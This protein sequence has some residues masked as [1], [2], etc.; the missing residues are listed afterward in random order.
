M[1]LR[2][3]SCRIL[4]AFLLY[5]LFLSTVPAHAGSLDAFIPAA[6]DQ[7]KK[8][9]CL[10]IPELLKHKKESC[11]IIRAAAQCEKFEKEKPEDSWKFIKCDYDSV[12]AQN[13]VGVQDEV[14]ACIVGVLKFP[15]AIVKG[16]AESIM[17]KEENIRECNKSVACKRELAA[18]SPTMAHLARPENEAEL[19]KFS[20]A[21]LYSKKVEYD[22]IR[23]Q[24]MIHKQ[25]SVEEYYKELGRNPSK[26]KT[27]N[28]PPIVFSLGAIWEVVKQKVASDVKE[29]ACYTPTEQLRIKCEVFAITIQTGSVATAVA[30]R[31]ETHTVGKA[32]QAVTTESAQALER[33]SAGQLVRIAES[34]NPKKQLVEAFGQ[35]KMTTVAENEA[36]VKEVAKTGKSRRAMT[37]ENSK[38]KT[39][40]DVIFKDEE[41]VTALTNVALEMQLSKLRV[42]EEQIRKKYPEFRLNAFSDFKSLRMAYDD[43]PGA[44]IEGQIKKALTEAN[45]EYATYLTRN[46]LVR[47]SDKPQDWFKATVAES[48]DMA[49]LAAKYARESP[50]GSFFLSGSDPAFKT[51]AKQEFKEGQRLHRDVAKNFKSTSMLTRTEDGVVE[52]HRD[53]FEILRKNKNKP[54]EAKKLLESHFGLETMS[55]KNFQSLSDYFKKADA[56]APGLRNPTRE[57][58]TL[59]DA[60]H[61]GVAVD[62]IGLGADHIQQTSGRALGSAK[63]ISDFLGKARANEQLLTEDI[64]KRKEF[65]ESIFKDVT[66]EKSAKVICSGD[67]CKAYLPGRALTEDE[68]KR[69]ADIVTATGGEQ[70][71]LRFAEVKGLTDRSVQDLVS[72]QGENLEKDL[73]KSLGGVV[74]ARRLQGIN[75]SIL[76]RAKDAPGSGTAKLHISEAAGLRLTKK[77]REQ[78]ERA[79]QQVLF[80]SKVGYKP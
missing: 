32:A 6:C 1:G 67:G 70:G 30:R 37:V 72:K 2:V 50:D 77:E 25:M 26:E 60:P 63:S 7:Y 65:I 29:V 12:C 46:N 27:E 62:M 53:A 71:R 34:S 41:Y 28:V 79:F 64:Y 59:A 17:A 33:R 73:R 69:F 10:K 45:E 57:F 75:L 9:S 22:P 20:A 52:L 19:A 39:M 13:M 51:W 24:R 54:T 14:A 42:L 18:G 40:N 8:N 3:F 47:A 61:G 78:I 36:W 44:D 4:T 56:L 55:D 15:I 58:A 11:D 80:D 43:I 5:V 68:T 31:A 74:D 66:G 38:L 23:V 48:D 21:F 16:A 35:K 49:N 76:I